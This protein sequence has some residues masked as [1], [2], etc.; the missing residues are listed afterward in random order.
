M[1]GVEGQGR[2]AFGAEGGEGGLE[3]LAPALPAQL[4]DEE[5]HPVALLVL[6][7]AEAMEDAQD[8]LRQLEDLARRQELEQ[9]RA[10]GADGG[11]PSADRHASPIV[12]LTRTGPY[13]TRAHRL[14]ADGPSARFQ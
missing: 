11:R 10:G 3:L 6:E 5:L 1:V 2:A 4:L 7:V 12:S 14:E 9:L 8:R 13:H